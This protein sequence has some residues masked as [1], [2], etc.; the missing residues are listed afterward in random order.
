MPSLE[1]VHQGVST[2]AIVIWSL[3][4]SGGLILSEKTVK[5]TGLVCFRKSQIWLSPGNLLVNFW[6]GFKS[7]VT[8]IAET[9]DIPNSNAGCSL[10]AY[11]K[12]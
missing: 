7:R 9:F 5:K 12:C 6:S 1:G 4:Q 2:A 3:A 8:H 10:L 11:G